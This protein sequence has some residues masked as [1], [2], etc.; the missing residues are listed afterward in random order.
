MI[1]KS[2]HVRHGGQAARNA[3]ASVS[4][5]T[6]KWSGARQGPSFRVFVSSV[7]DGFVDYRDAARKAIKAAGAEP[8]MVNEDSPS[9]GTSSRNACLNAI[10]S[11]DCLLSIVGTRGGWTTPSG[12]LVVEEEFEHARVRNLPVL[13]FIQETRRDADAERFVRTLS[14]YVDGVFRTKFQ[15]PT[16]LEQQVERAVRGRLENVSPRNAGGR[17]LSSYFAPERYTSGSATLLRFVLE[18]ERREEVVDPVTIVS[19]DL[20]ETLLELGH[21]KAVRLFSFARA[22]STSM[23]GT[24]LVI[25][26][27]DGNGRHRGEEYVRFELA[28]SG[29]VI[30]D[31][32]VTG[33]SAGGS[34]VEAMHDAFV[35]NRQTVEDVLASFF[36]FSAAV[37]AEIDPNQRQERFFYN[38]GLRGLGYRSLERDPHPRQSYGM[39]ARSSDVVAAFPTSRVISRAALVTPR[40]EI[41]RV[42]ALLEREA[43]G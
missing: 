3:V 37:F 1:S 31:G 10:E 8:V 22:K 40:D 28:E 30:L 23:E 32:N 13:A 9:Q 18:P 38:V 5:S 2:G 43:R 7:V 20:A 35:I 4:S 39:S 12:R 15:T 33:R 36:R 34:A 11:T 41:G 25:Q 14:D 6:T 16:D 21:S 42:I 26:Q 19:P 27:D 17:D 29:H 24:A